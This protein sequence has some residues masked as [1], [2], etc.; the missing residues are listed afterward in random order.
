MADNRA[1]LNG[2]TMV[3]SEVNT[4][5]SEVSVTTSEVSTTPDAATYIARH[6]G[7]QHLPL[8]TIIPISVVR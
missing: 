2:T 8:T 1:A 5:T 6:L 7:A 4:M 3:F